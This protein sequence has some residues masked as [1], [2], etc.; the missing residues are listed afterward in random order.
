MKTNGIKLK[1]AEAIEA[2]EYR[3]NRKLRWMKAAQWVWGRRGRSN[4]NLVA[5]SNSGGV[6]GGIETLQSQQVQL[7]VW[8]VSDL[9]D[10][11]EDGTEKKPQSALWQ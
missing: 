2:S 8:V 9:M 6:P 5:F 4:R 7:R 1:P 11:L 3:S 10:N